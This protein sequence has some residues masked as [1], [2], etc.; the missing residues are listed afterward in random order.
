M[1]SISKSATIGSAAT[2]TVVCEESAQASGERDDAIDC[3][4][5]V[6]REGSRSLP[7]H[8]DD[9]NRANLGCTGR[10]QCKIR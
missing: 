6:Q 5:I 3:R 9:C 10:E 8:Y 2:A 1:N 4:R 7:Q